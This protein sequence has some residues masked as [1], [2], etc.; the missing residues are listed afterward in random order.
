MALSMDVPLSTE[1]DI[2]CNRNEW[3][4]PPSNLAHSGFFEQKKRAEKNELEKKRLKKKARTKR[5][6]KKGSKKV[7]CPVMLL[8]A[9]QL[10]SD[11]AGSWAENW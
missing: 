3:P 11:A 6:E 4:L 10:P 7:N 5:L 2:V 8:E 9:G 1:E